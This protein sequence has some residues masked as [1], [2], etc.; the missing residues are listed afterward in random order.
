MN[1]LIDISHPG[2]VHLFKN[3]YFKLKAKHNIIWTTRDI[4]IAKKL[5]DQGKPEDTPVQI[6]EGISTKHERKLSLTLKEMHERA[7]LTW[8]NQ[9]SPALLLVG[10]VFRNRLQDTGILTNR[11][12]YG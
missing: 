9:D 12:L 5:L 11:R 1:I 7:A 6:I 8:F 4:P 10:A 3:I 2:Q